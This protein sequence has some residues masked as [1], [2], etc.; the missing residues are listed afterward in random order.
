[1]NIQAHQTLM[2]IFRINSTANIECLKNYPVAVND[3][4]LYPNPTQNQTNVTIQTASLFKSA[5]SGL[6]NLSLIYIIVKPHVI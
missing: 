2:A 4:Y 1:M 3:S 6:F 5:S